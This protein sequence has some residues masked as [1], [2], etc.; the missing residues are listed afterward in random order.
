MLRNRITRRTFTAAGAG[1]AAGIFAGPALRTAAKQD[2]T[3]V[4]EVPQGYV[5]MRI[6]EMANPEG[7]DE[8][9]PIVMEEFVPDVQALEGY[10]GYLLGD[11]VDNDAQS[12]SVLLME[13]QSQV[14]AFQDLAANFVGGLADT[15]AGDVVGTTEWEGE[16]LMHG[17]PTQETGATPAASPAVPLLR[18]GY[19]AVRVH[20]STPGTDPRDFV[21]LAQA[22][23]VPRMEAL[24]GFEGYLWY[25]IET[26]F[27]AISLFDSEESAT[28]SNEEAL[29]WAQE[30]LTEYT[31]GNPQIIDAHIV[32]AEFPLLARL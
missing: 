4:V 6:R 2:A 26:G 18:D 32:W 30:F 13:E 20:T 3:P 17:F 27:V 23:F 11:V 29:D 22:D 21:P 16:M 15:A 25:P 5:S 24:E 12:L 1:F 19:A 8:V 14:A 9:N 31:D 7:R 28:A 10:G